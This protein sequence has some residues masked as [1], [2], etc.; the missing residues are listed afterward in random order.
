MKVMKR[1]QAVL[2]ALVMTLALAVPA[3]AANPETGSLT[4]INAV[5]GQAYSVYRIFDLESYNS[6]AG[7]YVYTVNEK[8]EKFID[9]KGSVA[10]DASKG[11]ANI[12]GLDGY[13]A[14]DDNGHVTWAKKDGSNNTGMA[15]FAKLALA[16]AKTNNVSAVSTQTA[17]GSG[18]EV[19]LVFNDLELG[20]YLV[21]SNVGTLCSLDTTDPNVSV[22]DKNDQPTVD[23]KVQ[24]DNDNSWGESNGAQIGDTVNFKV[25]ITAQAGA[26]KYILHEKMNDGLTF[27]SSSIQVTKNQE[28]NPLTSGTDYTVV[29]E[30][31]NL[32][33]DEKNCT[34]HV[35][36]TD[37]LCN[38]LQPGDTL[39][40]TYS[41]VLNKNADVQQGE[42]N[43]VYLSYGE[44]SNIET[45]PAETTTKTY[46]FQIIKTNDT[47]T[48]GKYELLEGAR[49]SLF[50]QKTGGDSI[51]FVDEGSGVYRVATQEE[52]KD[53]SVVKVTEIPAGIPILK[54]LDS[55]KE[56]WLEETK[57]PDGYNPIDGRTKIILTDNNVA[58]NGVIDTTD[59]T[60][61][62]S[63]TG[64]VQVQNSKGNK[65]PNTGGM[66]TSIFYTVGSLLIIFAAIVLIMVLRHQ[67]GKNGSDPF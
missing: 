9:Q 10:S 21:D 29:T 52:I 2:L 54:G 42:D 36:F 59:N 18:T 44:N 41:A 65:L 26:Q 23:K 51:Q 4:I 50:T 15:E 37:S 53:T 12:S 5:P 38:S 6:D 17:T 19:S 46:Q 56:Y 28:T 1:L 64:G 11:V 31:N 63:I 7:A 66:G 67:K 13:V 32:T 27:D 3:L 43:E 45:L 58:G 35:M 14:V 48:N 30:G 25:I 39:T 57:A 24:E 62:S 8:W 49:F 60:F 40:V 47:E 33:H 34:F 55:N 22:T 16:W 61:D 20:Y